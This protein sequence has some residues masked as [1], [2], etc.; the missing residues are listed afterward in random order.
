MSCTGEIHVRTPFA[1]EAN[2][3]HFNDVFLGDAL[4]NATRVIECG[5][6]SVSAGAI[7][8]WV[9]VD[10]D[11]PD[12]AL[13]YVEEEV[14]PDIRALRVRAS[15]MDNPSDAIAALSVRPLI[16]GVSAGSFSADEE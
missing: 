10:L 12:E 16:E 4:I 6:V 2:T 14:F 15:E 3:H 5:G 13:T 11:D 8:V 1:S 7:T 9:K